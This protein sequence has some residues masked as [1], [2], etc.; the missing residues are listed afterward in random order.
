MDPE[1]QSLCDRWHNPWTED[2]VAVIPVANDPVQ[3]LF[4][5]E[6]PAQVSE[7]TTTFQFDLFP[8]YENPLVGEE[9]FQAY[10]PQ[11]IYQAAELFKLTVATA[12]LQQDTPTIG[13]V[14]LC[15]SRMGPW[16]PWMKMGDRPGYLIY[17]ATG[18]KALTVEDLPSLLQ[19]Q[20]ERLPQYREAPSE[21]REGA[22][23][24]SWLYFQEHF[25]AYLE[26]AQFP[27]T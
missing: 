7:R 18:C 20:L 4:R 27:L 3:G 1:N 16:L 5:R 12:D 13:D 24:T 21:Y 8:Y 11:P 22:D 19:A 10:S 25:E 6:V 26:G 2:V 14:H 15:W 17:S 23:M 9:R